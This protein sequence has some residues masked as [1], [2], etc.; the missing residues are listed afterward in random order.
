[1]ALD[2]AHRVAWARALDQKR[3]V[4]PGGPSTDTD[5]AHRAPSQAAGDDHRGE[6]LV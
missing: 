6:E 2:D 4:Q 3:R 1:M 5:D